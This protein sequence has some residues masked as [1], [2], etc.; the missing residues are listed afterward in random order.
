MSFVPS[1]EGL[2]LAA[3][4]QARIAMRQT[5]PPRWAPQFFV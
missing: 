5:A 4:E 2:K 3:L 1:V